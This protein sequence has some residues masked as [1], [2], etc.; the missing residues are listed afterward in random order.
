MVGD[1][2]PSQLEETSYKNIIT[3]AIGTEPNVEPAVHECDIIHDDIFL[4]CSDGLSDLLR[5]DEIE[6]FCFIRIP[7][8]MRLKFLSI[9]QK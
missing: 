4:M 3:K 9:T 5:R 8:M 7:W 2:S 6:R 1:A